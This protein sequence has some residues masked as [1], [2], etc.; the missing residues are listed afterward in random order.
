MRDTILHAGSGWLV[1]LVGVEIAIL[2]LVAGTYRSLLSRLGHNIKLDTL[3]GVHLQ[4]VVVGTVTPVGGPSSMAIFVH[5]LRQLG[6]RPTD[7]LLAVSIKSVIGNIA[8]LMLLVPVLFAQDPSPLLIAGTIGLVALVAITGALLILGLRT[9]KPPGWMLSRIPRKGLRWLVQVRSHHISI[10]ALAGPF[11]MMM[12]TKLAGIAMLFIALQAV[13]YNAEIQVPMMA[14]LVGMVFLMV[15]PVFQGIGVVEVTMALALQRLGVPP[16]AAV[17]AT[18]LT[19]AGELWLPLAAG[20]T[21]QALDTV[22]RRFRTPAP[23]GSPLG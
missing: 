5:A 22:G 20:I 15:A 2:L 11:A 14:Y 8:F 10:A 1:A 16:A 9:T 3:I 17:G 23:H 4:R 18:L 19:R 12:T 13:G 7:A 21:L 6:V